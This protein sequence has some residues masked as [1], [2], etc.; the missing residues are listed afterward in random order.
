MPWYTLCGSLVVTGGV[1]IYNI[2]VDTSVSR[3]Y[4]YSIIVGLG[5]GLLAQ[6]LFSVPQATVETEFIASK[7][8]FITCA[9]VWCYHRAR[10]CKLYILE[11][12]TGYN[13]CN[14][15]RCSH[16]RYPSCDY[17]RCKCVGYELLL[18]RGNL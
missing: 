13:Y 2:D 8:G 6:A 10:D 12:I 5:T 17:R 3:I 16:V 14:P 18:Y 4:N 11:Q 1:L 9:Q 15:S 7:V